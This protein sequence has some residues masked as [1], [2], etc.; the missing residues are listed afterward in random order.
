MNIYN[1]CLFF[2]SNLLEYSVPNFKNNTQLNIEDLDL[3]GD[4]IIG[5]STQL[6]FGLLP[7]SLTFGFFSFLSSNLTSLTLIYKFSNV[8]TQIFLNFGLG[9]LVPLE[10]ATIEITLSK[11]EGSI[12]NFFICRLK[13]NILEVRS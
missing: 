1:Q 10:T 9:D 11:D 13:N 8:T 6:S 12:G 5:N 7:S 4:L 3:N 2:V